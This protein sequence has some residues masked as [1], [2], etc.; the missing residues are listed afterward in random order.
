MSYF[1]SCGIYTLFGLASFLVFLNNRRVS[2]SQ[3]ILFH[4]GL[5]AVC[6]LAVPSNSKYKVT[7]QHPNNPSAQT[8]E[9]MRS[10]R[11]SHLSSNG[12]NSKKQ[13]TTPTTAADPF[14]TLIIFRSGTGKRY[15]VSFM[16]PMYDVSL[17]HNSV[18]RN[19]NGKSPNNPHSDN[20]QNKLFVSTSPDSTKRERGINAVKIAF[21]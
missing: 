16:Y 21:S 12:K 13:R 6:L 5:V 10:G 3:P 9:V 7:A 17:K 18:G 2:F 19:S 8:I 20:D 1:K 14:C 4:R 15:E 11:N